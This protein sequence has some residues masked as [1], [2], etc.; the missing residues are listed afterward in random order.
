MLSLTWIVF[1]LTFLQ[2][3]A[4]L[5]LKPKT[6][7]S[8]E[9]DLDLYDTTAIIDEIRQIGVD[10]QSDGELCR[11]YFSIN[12]EEGDLFV[13]FTNGRLQS[14]IEDGQVQFDV[15]V[16]VHAIDII[17]TIYELEYACSDDQCDFHFVFDYIGWFIESAQIEKINELVPYILGDKHEEHGE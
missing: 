1:F 6:G 2:S 15:S 9:F 12:F 17:R 3:F 14:V 4:L 11:I 13:Q 8:L 5:C 16:V 10:L 7:N